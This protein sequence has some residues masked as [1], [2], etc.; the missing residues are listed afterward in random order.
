MLKKHPMAEQKPN[1]SAPQLKE[2]TV[3]VSRCLCASGYSVESY[4]EDDSFILS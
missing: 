3:P 4:E 1:Y 2:I